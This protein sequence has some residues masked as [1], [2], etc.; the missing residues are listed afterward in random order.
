MKK[1]ATILLALITILGVFGHVD[2]KT[3]V[4]SYFRKSGTFVQTHYRTDKN[5]TKTDNWSYHG[6]VNPYT[7]KKGYKY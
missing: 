5:Y 2:A 1:F 7:G 3:R 4:S 6:N